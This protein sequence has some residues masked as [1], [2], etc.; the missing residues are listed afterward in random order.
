[1]SFQHRVVCLFYIIMSSLHPVVSFRRMMLMMMPTETTLKLVGDG[2]PCARL[3][4]GQS[5]VCYTTE[6]QI[7]TV[8][9]CK[10]SI[11]TC[12]TFQEWEISWHWTICHQFY[13][14]E[15]LQNVHLAPL[16]QQHNVTTLFEVFY[17]HNITYSS[18]Y[19]LL[20]IIF[21]LPPCLSSSVHIKPSNNE[22]LSHKVS[23]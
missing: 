21:T 17:H 12:G 18:L 10:K 16:F 13:M 11:L 6:L 14:V 8:A 9:A 22:W 19:S 4:S 5:R 7:D 20:V 23:K 3:D 2:K 1:M 15:K